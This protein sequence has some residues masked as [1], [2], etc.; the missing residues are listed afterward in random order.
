M[1][2]KWTLLEDLIEEVRKILGKMQEYYDRLEPVTKPNWQE[3]YK[4]LQVKMAEIL[5]GLEKLKAELEP[6]QIL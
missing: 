1:V 6:F 5:S 3:K 4:A 2:E